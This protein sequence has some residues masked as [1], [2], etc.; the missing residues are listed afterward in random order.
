[1]RI[2]IISDTH[3]LLRQEFIQAFKGCELIFHAG[4]IGKQ[5]MLDELKK[6]APVVVVKGNN[7]RDS[8]AENLP[9]ENLTK[10]DGKEIY[11]IHDLKESQIAFENS[12]IDID[13]V[14]SGHSHIYKE[15]TKENVLYLNP[16]GAGPKRL[17]RATTAMLLK[18]EDG[19]VKIQKVEL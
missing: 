2:G 4:D 7:D 8:W 18:I 9:I 19:I 14:I 12:D 11:M 6:I 10:A 5:E 1:M 17:G 15:E 13:I 16:G 3:G